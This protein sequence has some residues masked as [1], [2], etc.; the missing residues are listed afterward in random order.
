[1]IAFTHGDGVELRSGAWEAGP[2]TMP[3]ISPL[4]AW[5]QAHLFT[6][7]APRPLLPLLPPPL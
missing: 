2:S 1:M 5:L 3:S 4:H 7:A 6:K